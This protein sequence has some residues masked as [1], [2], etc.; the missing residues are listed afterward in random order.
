MTTV[1]RDTITP[2]MI[3]AGMT[4]HDRVGLGHVHAPASFGKAFAIGM[5]LNAAFVVLEVVFGFA[6]NSV[7]LLADAEH[8]L[9]DALGLVIQQSANS[10]R[11]D[12]E[13][14]RESRWWAGGRLTRTGR[15]SAQSI[16]PGFSTTYA[17]GLTSRLPSPP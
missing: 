5:A 7:A 12:L 10:M 14:S 6:S 13:D 15:S 17:T 4:H 11:G 3:M 1:M 16:L 8:N 2:S 9:S